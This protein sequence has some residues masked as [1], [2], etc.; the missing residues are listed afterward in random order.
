MQWKSNKPSRSRWHWRFAYLPTRM[1]DGTWVWWEE[2][3]ARRV[4]VG[5]LDTRYRWQRHVT[6]AEDW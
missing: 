2:Y 6:E 1:H 5:N 3:R 4:D